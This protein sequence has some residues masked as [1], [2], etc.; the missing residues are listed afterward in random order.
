MAAREPTP[1]SRWRYVRGQ[2]LEFDRVA[3]FTDAVFAIAMTLL[4]VSIDAPKL[5]SPW[6]APDVMLDA[7][8]EQAP[9]FFSFFLAFLLIGRYWLAHHEMFSSMKAVDR[10]FITLNLVYLS[11]V[12]FLPYP[13]ELVGKYEANPISVALFAL[14]LA[15]I[16][17]MESVLLRLAYRHDLLRIELGPTGYRYGMI[18][19]TT[20]VV[21][22]LV[23]IPIA[24]WNP[25]VALLTWL[26]AI[27]AG[28]WVDHRAGMHTEQILAP[29]D[30]PDER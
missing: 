2:G 9:Q 30:P 18:Q 6:E 3:F 23:S 22:F 16:S 24:F 4:I 5:P 29:T 19:S 7:L 10:S 20:P 21:L 13:T 1:R 28:M 8:R 15:A 17:G 26:L 14:C 12:A 11:F 25:T 27:P